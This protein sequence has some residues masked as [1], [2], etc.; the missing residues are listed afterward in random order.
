MQHCILSIFVYVD[1]GL[2]KNH[3]SL[4]LTSTIVERELSR[5]GFF[6]SY[7]SFSISF[8]HAEMEQSDRRP[9]HNAMYSGS[10]AAAARVFSFASH[11]IIHHHRKSKLAFPSDASVRTLNL[12]FKSVRKGCVIEISMQPPIIGKCSIAFGLLNMWRTFNL[13]KILNIDI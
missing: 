9:L 5:G 10:I 8:D 3:A 11:M 13:V 1:F 7:L 4:R 2:I 6:G 12:R